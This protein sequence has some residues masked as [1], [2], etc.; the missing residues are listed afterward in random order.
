MWLL[1]T[2]YWPVFRAAVVRLY[3]ALPWQFMQLFQGRILAP[4]FRV[5]SPLFLPLATGTI[6]AITVASAGRMSADLLSVKG[7]LMLFFR[8]MCGLA[9]LASTG[10][11]CIHAYG[12][13]R[14]VNIVV[15]QKTGKPR[16]YAFI[17]YENE[18]DFQCKYL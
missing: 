4:L 3:N 5:V 8:A 15:N 1:A 17:E 9:A 18:A 10:I 13:I 14:R 11:L 12:R 2:R 16:G 6:V 7:L